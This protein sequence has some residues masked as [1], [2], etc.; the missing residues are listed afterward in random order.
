MHE[1]EP[2]E[3]EAFLNELLS[4][5]EW[6]GALAR[7]LC[8]CEADAS[9]LEQ[10]TLVAALRTP[11]QWRPGGLRP[12]LSTVLHNARTNRLRKRSREQYHERAG[13]RPEARADTAEEL[14]RQATLREITNFVLD[15]PQIDREL[16]LM[17]FYEGRSLVELAREADIPRSTLQSRLEKA[18]GRLRTRLEV[19]YGGRSGLLLALT[20]LWFKAPP[21]PRSSAATPVA[22]KAAGTTLGLGALAWISFGLGGTAS[23]E[24][25]ANPA[26]TPHVAVDSPSR[27]AVTPQLRETVAAPL[28]LQPATPEPA[29]VTLVPVESVLVHVTAAPGT[30]GEARDVRLQATD[31]L[32]THHAWRPFAASHALVV[33][34]GMLRIHGLAKGAPIAHLELELP[35]FAPASHLT[36]GQLVVEAVVPEPESRLVEVQLQRSGTV[37]KEAQQ[38]IRNGRLSLHFGPE[39]VTEVPHALVE[40]L[41]GF[42]PGATPVANPRKNLFGFSRLP[43]AKFHVDPE[44]ARYVHL[45]FGTRVL[46]VALI[47]DS[48]DPAIL[49]LPAAELEAALQHVLL[50]SQS[51]VAL[52]ALEVSVQPNI[53]ADQMAPRACDARPILQERDRIEL[54]H[55]PPID[56]LLFLDAPDQHLM[57][58]AES[59]AS[60]SRIQLDVPQQ[61]WRSH[62]VRVLADGVAASGARI[63][64]DVERAHGGPPASFYFKTDS[65][66]EVEL[67][68][69]VGTGHIQA[70]VQKSQQMSPMVA[71]PQQAAEDVIELEL[72]QARTRQFEIPELDYP[73]DYLLI[74]GIGKRGSTTI[75][76]TTFD[77]PSAALLPGRYNVR[78]MNFIE[79]ELAQYETSIDGNEVVVRLR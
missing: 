1:I 16:V 36:N 56:Y 49:E 25:A 78:C 45:V 10:E 51:G 6:L 79:G 20:P 39:V 37:S 7:R 58:L 41:P 19:R 70:W 43:E 72:A 31:A 63:R 62:Q 68:A 59:G 24:V 21:V 28:N 12:W 18:L 32:G 3:H 75:A 30:R 60:G 35:A 77:V 17:R 66:G 11:P 38:A 71:L 69:L 64:L 42:A 57:L 52:D 74:E 44:T 27:T 2:P 22:L 67:P 55:L 23:P 76:Q 34:P 29:E 26:T 5:R 73:C 48:S 53:G 50:E 46:A 61:P 65:A 13:A 4:E 15:L 47:P 8:T 33:P 14:E 9:D 40:R 54:E